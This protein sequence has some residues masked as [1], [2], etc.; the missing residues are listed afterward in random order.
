MRGGGV[1]SNPGAN[2]YIRAGAT[3]N[4]DG[5]TWEH[6]WTDFSSVS[7]TRGDTYY[8][9]D[10]SYS[11]VTLDA[12]ESG[13]TYIYIKKATASDHGTE[14]GWVSTYGDGQATWSTNNIG[15]YIETGYW[16]I[17][18]Y[19]GG[20]S[21]WE[22]GH[23][24]SI[25]MSNTAGIRGIKMTDWGTSSIRNI[26]ISGF[27]IHGPNVSGVSTGLYSVGAAT[28]N[29]TIENCWFDQ[30]GEGC[31]RIHNATNWVIQYCALTD[32][33]SSTGSGHGSG[34]T[35]WY[36]C[37][38]NQFRWNR[39]RAVKGTGWFGVYTGTHTNMLV[40]GNVF[41]GQGTTSTS[42]I[43]YNA[44]SATCTTNGW[45]VAN[46]TFYGCN[47]V[48]IIARYT[49]LGSG[50]VAYNNTSYDCDGAFV[51]GMTDTNNVKQ[52]TDIF[53]NG[54][55]GDLHLTQETSTNGT[56]LGSPYNVDLDGRSRGQGAKWDIGA[57]EYV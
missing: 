40:H 33:A 15:W 35:F 3:G 48:P 25:T 34:C 44:D 7:W 5:S 12:P 14:T 6:A 30:T 31:L 41:Y 13:G 26:R 2:H 57:F 27:E 22:S 52:A 28:S 53:V 9:A 56:S 46:N 49:V 11:D 54:V 29:V 51:S 50:N 10:G 16:D 24:F 45:I 8:V 32:T 42:G 21:S 4:N 37:N 20:P 17:E 18:G 19:G 1:S 38:N 55:A 23:G 39:L 43:V 36:T 47:S